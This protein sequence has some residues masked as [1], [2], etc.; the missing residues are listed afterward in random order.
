MA[1]AVDGVDGELQASGG[2]QRSGDM[3][4]TVEGNEKDPKGPDNERWFTVLAKRRQKTV[5]AG[6][7]TTLGRSADARRDALK[8]GAGKKEAELSVAS[9]L[10]RLPA[11]GWKVTLRLREGLSVLQKAPEVSLGRAVRESAGVSLQEAKGDRFVINT[12]Q[13]TI[14]YHTLSMENAKKISK[15]EKIRIGDKDY[16][17]VTYVNAPESCG[18]GVI[19]GIEE[20]YSDKDV[21]LNLNEDEDNP[22]ILEARRMGKT[23]TFLLTFDDEEVPRKVFFMGA[24][25]RCFLY[26]KRYEVCY[27]CGGLGH[28]SDVCD[29]D[30]PRCRGCGATRP[31]EG[32]QC[33]P[34]CQLCGKNHVTGDKKC[35]NLFRTPYIVKKRRWEQKQAADEANQEELRKSRPSERSSSKTRSRSESFPR[36]QTPQQQTQQKETS[37]KVSWSGKV[38]QDSEKD[39]ENQELKELIK[40]QEEQI[41]ILIEDRKKEREEFLKIIEEMKREKGANSTRQEESVGDKEPKTDRP[42][43]KKKRMGETDSDSK[44]DKVTQDIT[45][46]NGAMMQFMEQTRAEFEKRD[47]ALKAEFEKR[48]FALKAEFD[49]FRTQLINI[50]NALAK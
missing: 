21:L 33:E 29:N 12:K 10:P 46:M 4:V 38:S 42:P 13:G 8:K 1:P 43:L 22:T 39:R 28:R 41:R 32:H 44:M 48:D 50:Q 23:R 36:L 7:E 40:R 18:R 5:P 27:K 26:K 19:H 9:N 2:S 25:L 20:M 24:I 49:W 35:R 30:E 37:N 34:Q 6:A 14:I 3:E 45:L 17:V 15:I 11:T 47:I 16:G 31:Q